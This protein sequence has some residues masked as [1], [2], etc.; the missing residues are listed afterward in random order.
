MI[1]RKEVMR[2]K[3]NWLKK[4]CQAVIQK[5]AIKA[6]VAIIVAISLLILGFLK[7]TILLSYWTRLLKWLHTE[8]TIETSG[9]WF[10][11]YFSLPLFVLLILGFILWLCFRNAQKLYSRK[12]VIVH[13]LAQW[14][15]D[16]EEELSK[17]K[18]VHFKDIDEKRNL[19]KGSTKKY[20][21]L[22]VDKHDT[23]YVADD[24]EETILI[25][26]C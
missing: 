25:Q 6:I 8:H 19:K 10:I 17:G 2:K 22:I 24:T 7:K 5:L 4:F 16:N 3:E 1:V 23:L 9:F 26:A 21:K 14:V 15:I 18:V 13:I 12:N 11:F 20:L